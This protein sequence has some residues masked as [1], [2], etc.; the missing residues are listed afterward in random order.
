MVKKGKAT[1][2][3]AT[4]FDADP[5]YA[6]FAAV[7][8]LPA[9]LPASWRTAL[10]PQTRLPYWPKLMRFLA[11]ERCQ[12]PILPAESD[13]F[14]AFRFTPLDK[15]KAVIIGQDPYPTPGHAHGLCFSV[16]PRV[17]L[18]PSLRNIFRELHAD[19][20]AQPVDHGCLEAWARR[21]VLL[22]NSCLT[23]RAGA[24]NS[25]AG[26]G[27]EAFTDAAIQAVN[28]LPRR[29]AFV[30]WGGF[31]QKKA[32]LIDAERHVAI[33]GVHPSPL[34]AAAGFFG[35][36]PFSRINEALAASGQ[37]PIEWQLPHAGVL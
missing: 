15:V 23:V 8:G 7:P 5:A 31:A 30:M 13:V 17:K 11:G 29:V 33:Q 25:H 9:D 32:K 3:A 26:K 24:P 20:G 18:P 1:E 34:S 35:S 10:E 14:N 6:E 4:R 36:K 22:L 12:A 19:V 16:R 21:G 2:P 28:A 37:E 27:W